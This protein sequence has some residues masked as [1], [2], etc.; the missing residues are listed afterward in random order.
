MSAEEKGQRTAV[1]PVA[2]P[3]R[4]GFSQAALC[5]GLF[6]ISLTEKFVVAPVLPG[7][8]AVCPSQILNMRY[9]LALKPVAP[10]V[11]L[12]QLGLRGVC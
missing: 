11:A 4:C 3:V 8:N 6:Y 10:D 9:L 7:H 1:P 12:C 5:V 2:N